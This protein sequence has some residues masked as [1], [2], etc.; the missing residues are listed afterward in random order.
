MK[1]WILEGWMD[2]LSK[3]LE[4]EMTFSTVKNTHVG[5]ILTSV[6]SLHNVPSVA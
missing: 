4:N 5:S 6:A 2:E 3:T 1:I